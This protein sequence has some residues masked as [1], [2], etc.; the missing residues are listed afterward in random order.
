MSAE[1]GIN[2]INGFFIGT[3][4]TTMFTS[5]TEALLTTIDYARLMNVDANSVSITIWVLQP[6]DVLAD[7]F[8]A[9]PALVLARDQH[10][11]LDEIIGTSLSGGGTI[12]AVASKANSVAMSLTGTLRFI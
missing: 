6:G 9:L 10:Y 11:S 5:S 7:N 2:L 3:S 8:K 12:V 1:T 4:N